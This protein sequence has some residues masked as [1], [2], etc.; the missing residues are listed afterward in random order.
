MK[1]F[2]FDDIEVKNNID[3]NPQNE[4][5]GI[6]RSQISKPEI[7]NEPMY[8][9]FSFDI[10][11]DNKEEQK[12]ENNLNSIST[13]PNTSNMSNINN[14]SN[15]VIK[16]DLEINQNVTLQNEVK[17]EEIVDKPLFS[18]SQGEID[19]PFVAK[20][21][22][23]P[24]ISEEEKILNMY[25]EA[26][27]E[28]KPIISYTEQEVDEKSKD[29]ALEDALSHTTKFSPFVK[30]KPDVAEIDIEDKKVSNKSSVIF[31]VILF[32][33]LLFAIFVIPKIASLI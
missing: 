23:P 17:K 30:D 9:K 31:L 4:M 11:I 10:N 13:L 16:E 26:N 22:E 24:K 15:N 29:D 3:S 7:K 19:N 28:I 1:E 18:S 5:S 2:V 32:I 21:P 12:V 20:A 8:K 33:I 25:K 14:I 27:E 6:D